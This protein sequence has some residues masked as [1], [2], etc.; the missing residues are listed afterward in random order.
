[1][2]DLG[3]HERTA[4]VTGAS[5]G[6][7]RGIAQVLG[8][9]GVQLALVARRR[10]L[11]ESLA[12]EIVELGARPPLVLSVDLTEPSAIAQIRA[13][14]LQ[15]F[16]RLDILVNNAG[17]SRPAPLDAPETVW[18]HAMTLSF[19][20]IRRLT[21]AFLPA[22]RQQGW[23]RIINI[24]GANEPTHLN[25]DQVAKAAQQAWAK[26]LSREIGRFGITVNSI[27]PGRI[28]SE[29][30]ERMYPTEAERTQFAAAHVPLGYFG[31][32]SDI[33]HMVAFLASPKARYVTGSIIYVDGGFHRF[34]F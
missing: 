8:R 32:P 16:E 25:A 14:V 6:I 4:L 27:A 30:I 23:G 17:G 3:L 1:V 33:G 19:D 31:D 20:A 28:K 2:V 22:M 24:T 12:E 34:S 26:G 7:G 13:D 29:Q 9:E 5:T 15:A 21:Q 18:Q 11:L 10:S